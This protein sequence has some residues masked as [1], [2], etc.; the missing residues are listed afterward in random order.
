M[1]RGEIVFS[2]QH[3]ANAD[4]GSFFADRKVEHRS[5]SLAL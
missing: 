5:R 1:M 4:R 2:L 3:I